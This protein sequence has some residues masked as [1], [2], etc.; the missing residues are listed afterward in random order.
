MGPNGLAI[1]RL[2]LASFLPHTFRVF[3][4]KLMDE[5]E[6]LVAKSFRISIELTKIGGGNTLSG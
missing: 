3:A 2:N 5:I 4:L 6:F 1:L